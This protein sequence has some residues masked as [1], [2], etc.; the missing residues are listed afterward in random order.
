VTATSPGEPA[1]TRIDVLCA[2][3]KGKVNASGQGTGTCP[4]C[5]RAGKFRF[6]V[7]AD[8]DLVLDC[9][10]CDGAKEIGEPRLP[11]LAEV[12]EALPGVPEWVFG[13]TAR[14][15]RSGLLVAPPLP[16]LTELRPA[17]N[18][19]NERTLNEWAEALQSERVVLNGLTAK[20][21][22]DSGEL[23]EAGIGYD[24]ATGRV[25]IPVEDPST[26]ELLTVIRR[27]FAD[28]ADPRFKSLIWDGSDGC[29]VFA[30][31][32][33]RTD[34]PVVICAGEK[35]A[36]IVCGHGYNGIA[37]TN[38]EGGVPTEARLRCLFGMDVVLLYDDDAAGHRG[39]PRVAAGL[40]STVATVRIAD[41]A[42]LGL[43]NEPDVYDVLHSDLGT[44][45]LDRVLAAATSWEGGPR[46]ALGLAADPRVI[47]RVEKLR[48]EDAAR[49]LF[50]EEQAA[51]HAVTLP[52]QTLD[53]VLSAPRPVEAPE[54]ISELHRVGYNSTIT[55]Q[56]KTGKTTLGGNLLRSLAD[57]DHFLRRFPV[58]KPT[59]RIGLLN[60]ELSES[61]MLDWLDD[62][63]I[64]NTDRIAVLNLR[65]VPFSLASERNQGEL[66][67]WCRDMEVEVLNLDPHRRA[68]AGFGEENNND[69][70]N[71]FTGALD[72]I[73]KAAGVSDLF[74]YV[75]TGRGQQ[76]QGNERA[77][78]AT[79]LDDWADQRWLLT[80][81]AQ[82]QDRYLYVDGRMQ[83][84][85]EFKLVYDRDTR[86]LAYE[87]GNRKTASTDRYA[88][89]IVNV[90]EVVGAAGALVGELEDRLGVT[91][92][93]ALSSALRQL[94]TDGLVVQRASGNGKRNW[95][96]E[97]AP[98]EA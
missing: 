58:L 11:W 55:A 53:V 39:A 73:K 85:P 21:N 42:L 61:D 82:T 60:Y 95:L 72:E 79:A 70:V 89:Q 32:G 77:R 44:D 18:L 62:Q 87:D 29:F 20:L 9:K 93:G 27:N 38:G 7:G 49:R 75:H 45:G 57:G 86:H 8:A 84:V 34:E 2:A 81:D 46:V 10:V 48:L 83:F 76:E 69:D 23:R 12:R 51:P 67:A 66:V 80:K 24:R 50:R 4:V 47:D 26:G 19:P 41:L 28:D 98:I 54:R 65:G 91:K 17:P 90:L 30:P 88:T 43:P 56:Y 14:P 35:D 36:L 22:L 74:L 13:S 25:L 71:R 33:I 1:P 31:F 97:H 5:G 16:T 92:K 3:V 6:R 78:G 68:F 64:A 40:W 94:I 37:F 96:A 52:R 63:G 59:G 15:T